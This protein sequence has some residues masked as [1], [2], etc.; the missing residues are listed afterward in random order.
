ML[1]DYQATHT[2]VAE[3]LSI[4][5]ASLR[6]AKDEQAFWENMATEAKQAN[7]HSKKT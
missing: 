1:A 3:K 5:E 7:L 6:E 4:T 2:Q